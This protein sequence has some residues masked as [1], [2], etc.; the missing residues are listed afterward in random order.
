MLLR[1]INALLLR[2]C[3]LH[4]HVRSNLPQVLV[5]HDVDQEGSSV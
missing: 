2:M 1:L 5:Y 3:D 4:I